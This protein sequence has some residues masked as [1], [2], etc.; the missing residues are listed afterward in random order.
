[1]S[2]FKKELFDTARIKKKTVVDECGNT[3]Q[4]MYYIEYTTVYFGFI[5]IQTIFSETVCDYDECVTYHVTRPSKEELLE[6]WNTMLIMNRERYDIIEDMG[7][8]NNKECE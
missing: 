1:M 5:A 3:H 8:A 4:V 7:A 6:L 2:W